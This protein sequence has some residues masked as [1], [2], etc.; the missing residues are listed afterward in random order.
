ML[1][2]VDDV[3]CVDFGAHCSEG[4]TGG[5]R[6][7]SSG[8][9]DRGGISW[10][11]DPLHSVNLEEELDIR[12]KGTAPTPMTKDGVTKVR[13]ARQLDP[14][15]S[16]SAR[17]CIAILDLVAHA[18][19]D[20]PDPSISTRPLSQQMSKPT[21]GTEFG[22][23]GWTRYLLRQL[24]EAIEIGS[25]SVCGLIDRAIDSWRSYCGGWIQLEENN[26]GHWSK[27]QADRQAELNAVV[28]GS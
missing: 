5:E 12:K 11:S 17:H 9:E 16:R 22:L 15:R 19:Q 24:E 25:N 20:R 10:E 4:G 18:A 14:E 2:H 7:A 1:L 28:R 6:C 23:K 8:S 21:A 13:E 3:L 26:V 27:L